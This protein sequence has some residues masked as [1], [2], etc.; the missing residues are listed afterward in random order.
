MK[1]E[2]E[3][4][5]YEGAGRRRPQPQPRSTI[6]LPEGVFDQK[7]DPNDAS[8][9]E[10]DRAVSLTRIRTSDLLSEGEIQGLV[11]GY[12]RYTSEEG[13]TGY[14]SADLVKNKSVTINSESFINLQSV[15]FNNVPLVDEDGKFNFQQINFTEDKGSPLPSTNTTISDPDGQ[16]LSVVRNIQ[17]RLRGPNV[18]V[19]ADGS[20][21]VDPNVSEDTFAKYY[22]INN[23]QCR[24]AQVNIRFNQLFQVN[25]TGPKQV[26][27]GAPAGQGFGDATST[28]VKIR[29]KIREIFSSSGGYK[30]SPNFRTVVSKIIDGKISQ[31]Y[32]QAISFDT[33]LTSDLIENPTFLGFEVK[34]IRLTADS[35]NRDRSD[36]TTVDSLIEYYE[37]NFGYPSSAIISCKFDAE[38]FSQIPTRTFEVDLLKVKVPSNYNP[39][40]KTYAGDWDGTFAAEKKWTD[41]PAWCFYDV[42][43][44]KR[45]GLGDQIDKNLIDKWSL[46]SIAQY[47]DEM[48]ADGEGGYEPRFTCNVYFNER[49]DAYT[50]LQDF[51]SI[52]RGMTYYAGGSVRTFQDRPSDPIYTFTNANVAGGEFAY[53]STSRKSRFNTAVVR[54]ND[55][56]NDYLPAIE[57]VEDIDGVR[58]N[59]VIRKEITAVGVTKKSQAARIGNWILLTDNLE[60][61]SIGFSAGMEAAILEPGDVVRVSDN[62]KNNKRLGGRIKDIVTGSAN[63]K[64]TLDSEIALSGDET[65]EFSLITPTYQYEPSLM[66][67]ASELTSADIADIS[68]SQMQTFS[69]LGSHTSG[70]TGND[71]IVRTVITGVTNFG[72]DSI[73]HEISGFY[74]YSIFSNGSIDKNEDQLY[75]VI[76]VIEGD[77][78]FDIN[79]VIYKEEKYIRADETL[80][81]ENTANFAIPP[82]PDGLTLTVTPLDA[83]GRFKKI[84]C[85]TDLPDNSLDNIKSVA[86]YA[87]KGVWANEDFAQRGGSV[88]DKTPDSKYIV[89]VT[90]AAD[91]RVLSSFAPSEDGT[92]YIR[93]YSRNPV[94][95]PSDAP[96]SAIIEIDQGPVIE[97]MTISDLALEEVDAT[98]A[99]REKNETD[100]VSPSFKWTQTFSLDDEDSNLNVDLSNI[101]YRVTVREPSVDSIPTPII[102]FEETGL[103]LEETVYQFTYAKNLTSVPVISKDGRAFPEYTNYHF[104]TEPQTEA[105][106]YVKTGFDFFSGQKGPMRNYDLV[107]EAHDLDGRSSVG[108]DVKTYT[109]GTGSNSVYSNGRSEGYDILQVRNFGIEQIIFTPDNHSQNCRA[110]IQASTDANTI[111]NSFKEPYDPNETNNKGAVLDDFN[112]NYPTAV[113]LGAESNDPTKWCTQQYLDFNGDLELRPFRDSA[114]ETDFSAMNVSTAEAAVVYFADEW[115]DSQKAKNATYTTDTFGDKVVEIT[116]SKPTDR[117]QF[118]FT[119]SPTTTDIT[120]TVTKRGVYV[121][122]A[123]SINEQKIVIPANIVS[124][125]KYIAVTLLDSFEVKQLKDGDTDQDTLLN[126]AKNFSV[127]PA[128][129]VKRR[130]E[131]DARSAF[132]AYASVR[133]AGELVNLSSSEHQLHGVTISAST[134]GIAE[135]SM[136][137][138]LLKST[139]SLPSNAR[140][141]YIKSNPYRRT[142]T[143]HK[144]NLPRIRIRILFDL[145]EP[146]PSEGRSIITSD[147]ASIVGNISDNQIAVEIPSEK[148]YNIDVSYINNF[149]SSVYLYSYRSGGNT[150]ETVYSY[151]YG[152]NIKAN[153]TVTNNGFVEFIGVLWNGISAPNSNSITLGQ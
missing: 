148:L 65:Y 20:T 40:L 21:E 122:S 16:G 18:I 111:T 89:A 102:Y 145:E 99:V 51:A 136:D 117:T 114:G 72:L 106:E 115:F 93:S 83:E 141:N 41:N 146:I 104:P 43:T 42:L 38:Y 46:Y 127:S 116:S 2:E 118:P 82:A 71:N 27:P 50:M 22:R 98:N 86:I 39:I 56:F 30:D 8:S 129:F 110:A 61:E 36:Q 74:P 67:G 13:A 147:Q 95:T 53:Q 108:Y 69:F 153:T 3:K 90:D 96:A 59:G 24:R 47:C 125:G 75:R 55:R 105:S 19:N 73:D 124:K 26:P 29:V 149:L 140:F 138:I 11:T 23:K 12:Y 37:D 133:N 142:A 70:E 132:R 60:T 87:K 85:A 45:Y 109:E 151:Y 84:D 152:L 62:T 121:D 143:F 139:D 137:I 76:S 33:G 150:R 101:R 80:K 14:N 120:T 131:P 10:F 94:G 135:G 79:G 103:S 113:A 68:R 88:T 123:S 66:T 126:N 4:I 64:I 1:E 32:L 119:D 57:V 144:N 9:E 28:K 17:E 63:T 91:S 128:S 77:R 35:I 107:V 15:S 97:S 48:I 58:R 112:F 34:I 5:V 92:Y 31:G 49:L 25:K 78:G 134:F 130:G 100:E 54:Y 44:S 81:L 6:D 7:Q 52:F